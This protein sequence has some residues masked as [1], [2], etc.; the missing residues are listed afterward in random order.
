MR[1][2]G[3]DDLDACINCTGAILTIIGH[4][5]LHVRECLR[6]LIILLHIR[7]VLP[8]HHHHGLLLRHGSICVV[9]KILLTVPRPLANGHLVDIIH[10]VINHLV[11]FVDIC[12]TNHLRFGMLAIF[13][14]LKNLGVWADFG[15]F[16]WILI[17]HPRLLLPT[18]SHH[19][20]LL[21]IWTS[22]EL[23]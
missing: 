16:E 13:A 20:F 1:H 19:T 12:A 3:R 18:R 15:S 14:L 22:V 23:F 21:L 9:I 2:R 4:W 8:Q 6:N 17:L 5:P 10:K 11:V 7:T